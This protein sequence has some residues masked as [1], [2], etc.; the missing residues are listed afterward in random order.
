MGVRIFGLKSFCLQCW[1]KLI[2]SSGGDF[3]ADSNGLGKEG[4]L[5]AGQT[6][7]DHISH[8]VNLRLLCLGGKEDAKFVCNFLETLLVI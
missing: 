8:R 4:G 1:S 5:R 2:F 7:L 6:A 3:V